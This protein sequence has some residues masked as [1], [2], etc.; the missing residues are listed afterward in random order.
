MYTGFTI[1]LSV[2][3][4]NTGTLDLTTYFYMKVKIWWWGGGAQMR[5]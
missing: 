2:S 1:F 4:T 3:H 5:L